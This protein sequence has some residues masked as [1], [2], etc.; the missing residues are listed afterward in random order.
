MI[1]LEGSYKKGDVDAERGN[2]NTELRRGDNARGHVARD[3]PPRPEKGN[4]DAEV[5]SDDKKGKVDAELKRNDNKGNVNAEKGN[6]NNELR[7]DYNACGHVPGTLPLAR[8]KGMFM[9]KSE[10]T[11][12]KGMSML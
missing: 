9:L 4:V 5:G 6:V 2:V 11:L 12:R 8:R 1:K 3:T 7:R 10:G